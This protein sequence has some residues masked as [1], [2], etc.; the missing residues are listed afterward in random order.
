MKMVFGT[1]LKWVCLSLQFFFFLIL[2]WMSCKHQTQTRTGLLYARYIQNDLPYNL[3][4]L[5]FLTGTTGFQLLSSCENVIHKY[6]QIACYWCFLLVLLSFRSMFHLFLYIYSKF[7]LFIQ[8]LIMTTWVLLAFIYIFIVL[9]HGRRH[10]YLSILFHS[11]LSKIIFLLEF[12][13]MSNMNIVQISD[14][15]ECCLFAILR[16]YSQRPR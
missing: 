6:V 9:P 2:R 3:Q 4:L 14:S 10:T 5:D 12:Y 11:S 1:I 16:I 8:L 15:L 13:E 7:T